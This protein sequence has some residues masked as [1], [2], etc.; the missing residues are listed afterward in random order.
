MLSN[1]KKKKVYIE[2]PY[3]GAATDSF[4][5]K[6]SRIAGN[7][8]P[9][10]DVRFFARPPSS[11]QIYFKTKDPIPKYLQSGII[12]SVKCGDCGDLYVGETERQGIRRLW[13][14][15]APKT[16]FQEQLLSLDPRSNTTSQE[17]DY[18]ESDAI[19]PTRTT[20]HQVKKTS[21]IR[22]APYPTPETLRRSARI[23]QKN[24][25]TNSP[26]TN[27]MGQNI[28]TADTY[29][30]NESRKKPPDTSISNH[31]QQTGHRIDWEGFKVV[32]Q[33]SHS[34][35]LL[36]KESLVIKAY[37]TPLNRT[38]HSV[39]MYVFPEGLPRALIPDPNYTN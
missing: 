28:D 14:H 35:K 21:R 13:E 26:N 19:E 15:G 6:L 3:T 20:R 4:K 34:Y 7:L 1:V 24:E 10:V 32:W 27:Q 17:N 31:Q 36:V 37:E 8:R 12:Y 39:P 33:D 11:V 38:T 2:I 23:R 25:K 18:D 9:D 22:P 29:S 5:K 30:N 16:L